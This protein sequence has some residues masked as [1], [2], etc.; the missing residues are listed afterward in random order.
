MVERDYVMQTETPKT[1]DR[2]V[3]VAFR[4][5]RWIAIVLT[6]VFFLIFV[7]SGIQLLRL[8]LAGG[9]DAPKYEQTSVG[10]SETGESRTDTS[11]IKDRQQVEREFGETIRFVV[12]NYSL[13]PQSYTAIV[14]WVVAIEAAKRE[15]FVSGLQRYM[16]DGTASA[17]R[18]NVRVDGSELANEFNRRFLAAV[19][20]EQGAKSEALKERLITAGVLA[21]SALLFFLFLAIPALLQIE[22]NTRTHIS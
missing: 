16:A 6:V 12:E 22:R 17:K 11:G 21:G 15:T 19:A 5:G 18:R 3:F 10:T 20:E 2:I 13:S 7:G 1:A 4:L 14:S 9:F 8:S